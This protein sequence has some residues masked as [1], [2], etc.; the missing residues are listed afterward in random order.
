M[1][2]PIIS[3]RTRGSRLIFERKPLAAGLHL[4]ATPIGNA[5]D[6]TLRALDVLASADMLAAEDTRVL[7]RLLEIHGVPLG[8][9]QIVA[10]HDHSSARDR[11]RLVEAVLAGRSVAYASDAGTPLVADPGYALAR[12]ILAQGGRVEALPGASAVLTGLSVSGLPTDK[13]LFLGFPPQSAETRQSLFAS[14]ATLEASVIFYESPR[15]VHE[16]LDDLCK[17]VGEGRQAV[18]CRELTKKF[19]EVLRGDLKSLCQDLDGRVIK[20]ECVVILGHPVA[21][22]SA[23]GDIEEALKEALKTMRIKDA[24]T[25]V[26]GSFAIARRDVYQMALKLGKDK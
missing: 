22:Q 5:R 9:R 17:S 6:I 24:A 2:E 1:V 19:E 7:R 25:A 21:Q 15:R 16:L 10:Y 23:A 26:A 11:G 14:I 8:G 4:V 20:G 3:Q 18:L 13:F 12:D